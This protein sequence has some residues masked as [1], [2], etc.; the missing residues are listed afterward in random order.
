VQVL[1]E[2]SRR[3]A[4]PPLDPLA[5][6]FAGF[7]LTAIKLA[8]SCYATGQHKH[9]HTHPHGAGIDTH[10]SRLPC[11]Y[12]QQFNSYPL[13]LTPPPTRSPRFYERHLNPFILHVFAG[14]AFSVLLPRFFCASLVA[15]TFHMSPSSFCA[16]ISASCFVAK[17]SEPQK[18]FV[19]PHKERSRPPV[20][21]Q[22][23][24]VR[25]GLVNHALTWL[26]KLSL[27]FIIKR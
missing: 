22:F 1:E 21:V 4:E 6:P 9:A 5:T 2:E 26:A 11:Y 15:N 19:C 8:T 23:S 24:F 14:L 7:L 20:L 13:A 16:L 25:H 27:Q 3:P 17:T 10:G 12:G 18:R